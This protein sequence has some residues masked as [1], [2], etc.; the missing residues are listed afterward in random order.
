MISI[1]FFLT[2]TL[3]DLHWSDFA[4]TVNLFSKINKQTKVRC[5]VFQHHSK[6]CSGITNF[7]GIASV[8]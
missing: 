5:P 4:L 1:S 3:T 7:E 2:L 8:R 6:G